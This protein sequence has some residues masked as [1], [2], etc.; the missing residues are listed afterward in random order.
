MQYF[1]TALQFLTRIRLVKEAE[2]SASRFGKSVVFFPLVGMVIGMLLLIINH[3][4]GYYLSARMI[5]VLLVISGFIITGGLHADG[6]MD[7]ADGLL[8]GRSRER[9]LEIMKDSRVGSGGVMVF[10]LL[11]AVKWAVIEDIPAN[12]L[13]FGLFAAPILSRL[14]LVMAITLFPYARREGMGKL[15]AEHTSSR[16]FI[17][18]LGLAIVLLLPLMVYHHRVVVSF[19]VSLLFGGVFFRYVSSKLGG[20]TGDVYGAATEL[21]EVVVLLLFL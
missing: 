11:V 16:D 21:T 9:M 13:P 19:V 20:L 4:F 7:T 15:F 10:V 2:W 1:I 17:Y 12:L 6:L 14:V 3:V 5:A 8:S 18:A